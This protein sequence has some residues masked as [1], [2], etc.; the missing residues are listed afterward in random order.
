MFFSDPR[1]TGPTS[2]IQ[3]QPPDPAVRT[4]YPP[5]P[6]KFLSSYEVKQALSPSIRGYLPTLTR[7]RQSPGLAEPRPPEPSRNATK[8]P[9]RPPADPNS[10][11]EKEAD[12]PL[13]RSF[14]EAGRGCAF[15]KVNSAR[16][17]GGGGGGP[18]RP[19]PKRLRP[20]SQKKGFLTCRLRRGPPPGPRPRRPPPRHPQ[21]P[22]PAREQRNPPQGPGGRPLPASSARPRAGRRPLT[23]LVARRA[24]LRGRGL[25]GRARPARVNGGGTGGPRRQP[26]GR[27]HGFSQ[28]FL[29]S[30]PLQFR[31]LLRP[32]RAAGRRGSTTGGRAAAAPRERRGGESSAQAGPNAAPAAAALR[33]LTPPPTAAPGGASAAHRPARPQGGLAPR[34]GLGSGRGGLRQ[35]ARASVRAREGDGRPPGPRQPRG[36][37]RMTRFVT[38]TACAAGT[39]GPARL[40]PFRLWV[41]GVAC[42]VCDPARPRT[43]AVRTPPIVLPS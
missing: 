32:E 33:P 19:F 16:S 31:R 17:G 22:P 14:R 43:Y 38:G 40:G 20:P 36:S 7:D 28:R 2:F 21:G 42:P 10:R 18:G 13:P 25:P 24:A 15:L 27:G 29:S 9:P 35:A 8:Q 34:Q 11:D 3:P 37:A 30:G 23:V 5:T 41:T 26:G 1:S 12:A 4:P 39:S 6:F